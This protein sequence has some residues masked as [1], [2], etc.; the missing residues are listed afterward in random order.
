MFTLAEPD[1][2]MFQSFSDNLKKKIMASP[3][4]EKLQGKIKKEDQPDTGASFEDDDSIP[5]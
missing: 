1:M 3:E 2:V 5:F 4:W